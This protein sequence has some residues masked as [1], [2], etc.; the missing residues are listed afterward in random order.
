MGVGRAA[1]ERSGDLL[2][3]PVCPRSAL[4]RAPEGCYAF[5]RRVAA[6]AY[7]ISQATN[8]LSFVSDRRQTLLGMVTRD[9]LS[10]PEFSPSPDLEAAHMLRAPALE[11][12]L[13]ARTPAAVKSTLDRG[14][15]DISRK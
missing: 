11:L 9:N 7:S 14:C 8:D 6:G 5:F 1:A 4:S 12:P 2:R 10:L 15:P 3:D 13:L